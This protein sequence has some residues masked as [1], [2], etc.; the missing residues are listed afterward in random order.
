MKWYGIYR[1]ATQ[2]ATDTKGKDTYVTFC[3]FCSKL[4]NIRV[5]DALL[6]RA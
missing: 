6:L 3:L 1:K 4:V 5:D 2:R